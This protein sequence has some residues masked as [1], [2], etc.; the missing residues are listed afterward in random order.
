MAEPTGG[1]SIPVPTGRR[2]YWALFLNSQLLAAVFYVLLTAASFA[3]IRL[4]A[5][6]ALWLNVSVWV[7]VNSRPTATV[8]DRVRRRALAVAGGYFAL[9]AVAGGLVTVGIGEAATGLRIAPLPPGYGPALLYSGEWITITLMP[10]YLVGYAA[11]AYLVYVTVID[12]AGSAAAG[13][14]GLF[15]CV[16]CSWP[17]LAS[18]VSAI[19]GGG[20]LLVTSALQVSYGLSTAVFLLTAGLLYWR[21]TVLPWL[22]RWRSA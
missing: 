1:L 20:S 19:T 3:S 2:L 17:I 18:V 11:L 6:A 4:V 7:V 12:A 16:S 8:A 13:L 21:P 15:S 22:Q 14:I 9:L 5:Y 10:N